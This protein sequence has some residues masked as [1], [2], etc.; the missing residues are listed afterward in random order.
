[1][2]NTQTYTIEGPEGQEDNVELP[3]DL[4]ELMR[5]GDETGPQVVGDVVLQAFAQQAHARVHHAEGGVS[6][7]LQAA[8]DIIE[9]LF[10][11]RFGISL[12]DAMGHQH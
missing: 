1:M 8:N 3:A 2:V 10:E 9:D 12:S 7:E 6:D 11:D 5:E 4:V